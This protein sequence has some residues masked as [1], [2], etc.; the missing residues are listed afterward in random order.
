MV[1]QRK[2][3][4][5]KRNYW[6]EEEEQMLKQWADKAQ[7]YQW[8]HNRSRQIYQSKNAWYT[9]PVIIISTITGTA[10]FAQERFSDEIKQYVVISIGTL[11][12]IAGIITTIYQFLKI[13]EINEGHRVA[14]LSWG[15]F[16]R[17]IE[18]ELRRHPL[19][20]T[21]ASEMIKFSKEEYNRLVEI[22][23]FITK[24]VL[25]EFNKKF[26]KN[27]ELTKPEIGNVINSMDIYKM[28]IDD[29]QKMIDELN[30]NIIS[31]N[32]AILKK[33]QKI[34]TQIDKFKKSF[35]S[36]NHRNP[37]REEI[38]KHMKFLGEDNFNSDVDSDNSNDLEMGVVEDVNLEIGDKDEDNN[39]E[40]DDNDD[41]DNDDNDN[42]DND[43]EDNVSNDSKEEVKSV[44]S[45]V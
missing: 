14:L 16:H 21:G 5:V 45:E 29:R 43:H 25:K 20:R 42:D 12:I 30:E 23:Q 8:M 13:S 17:H 26:K 2:S 35:Y 6:K 1:K 19:D 9:I 15:K 31:K 24:K 44:E 39:N 4:Q 37:T 7:C 28:N 18:T 32:N 27:K 36:L 3:K 38:D 40:G 22:S 34:E 33:E 10:N 11:S 41:N